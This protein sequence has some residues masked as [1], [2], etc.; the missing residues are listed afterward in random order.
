MNSIDDDIG[1]LRNLGPKSAAWL[2]AAGVVTMSDLAR[3]GAVTAFQMVRHREPQASLNLLWALHAGLAD[4]DWRQLSE[5]EK[6]R[7]RQELETDS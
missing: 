7:L 6:T 4:R 1:G 5:S 3:I 2:R